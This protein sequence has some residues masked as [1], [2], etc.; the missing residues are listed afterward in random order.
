MYICIYL[1]IYVCIYIYIFWNI[2]I[3][4]YRFKKIYINICIYKSFS[5]YMY[6]FIHP[7]PVTKKTATSTNEKMNT[8]FLGE[9]PWTWPHVKYN[10][11]GRFLKPISCRFL[12]RHIHDHGMYVCVCFCVFICVCAR[13]LD[14]FD[15]VQCIYMGVCVRVRIYIY[16]CVYVCVCVCACVRDYI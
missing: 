2:Y 7:S 11:W 13:E 5:E 16:M 12:S 6:W 9:S 8:R 10:T 3:Y 4:I 1:N 15:R 14:V